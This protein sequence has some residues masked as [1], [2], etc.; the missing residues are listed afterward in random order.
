[1]KKKTH[2]KFNTHHTH[3]HADRHIHTRLVDRHI[4]AMHMRE[5]NTRMRT[6]GYRNENELFVDN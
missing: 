1:M 3:V 6:H 2:A 5:N 4:H